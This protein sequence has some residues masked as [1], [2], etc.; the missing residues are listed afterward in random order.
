M[1]SFPVILYSSLSDVLAPQAADAAHHALVLLHRHVVRDGVAGAE[2]KAAESP[3]P[4]DDVLDMEHVDFTVREREDWEK[5]KPLLLEPDRRR[6]AFESYRRVKEECRS[7]S[8][9][10]QE[11]IMTGRPRLLA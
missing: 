3:A 7:G 10:P 2:G 8:T 9:K 4:P 5:V 11:C 1:R 6:I